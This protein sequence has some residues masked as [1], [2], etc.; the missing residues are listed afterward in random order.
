MRP[1][2]ISR[3]AAIRSRPAS[4]P[5]ST[6]RAPM[7]LSASAPLPKS[8][9][10]TMT[11]S[12][13]RSGRWPASAASSIRNIPPPAAA[14]ANIQVRIFDAINGAL[15]KALPERAMGAF[16]HWA[17]PIFGGVHDD[18][19]R[20]WVMYDLIFGGYGGR[21]R[22]GRPRRRFARFST[23]PICRSR[24]TRPATPS[25]SIAS[26]SS[27]IPAA[28]E[29]IAAVAEFARTL[30]SCAPAPPSPCSA[31]AIALP[32]YGLFGGQPGRRGQTL[33]VRD[34]ET[35][36]SARR[37]AG[38][39]SATTSSASAS[40]APAVMARRRTRSQSAAPRSQT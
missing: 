31:T 18:T 38:S 27:P 8:T 20:P 2:S 36:R 13:G 9:C 23:R 3:A 24:C 6:T 17:N 29:D 32:P 26:S 34:G 14:R 12:S 7:R 37:S 35:Q 33:L 19:G 40:P 1:L 16:S 25:C 10:R 22:Q 39:S 28:R 5:T 4:T 11:G 21:V 15:A 30:R